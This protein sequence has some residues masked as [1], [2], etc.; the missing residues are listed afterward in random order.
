M[1]IIKK[2][3]ITVPFL[4]PSGEIIYEMIGNP[5]G[6]GG[7]IKHSFVHVTLPKGKSSHAHYH[8]VSEETYYILSGNARM[9]I[10]NHEFFLAPNQACL[11]MPNEEH[12]IF[13]EGESSLEFLTISA[14]AFNPEDSFFV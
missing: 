11:I 1:R 4:A 5:K 13:N 3:D 8:K 6:I 14:P 12:Q 9:V 7:T 2:D 10:D